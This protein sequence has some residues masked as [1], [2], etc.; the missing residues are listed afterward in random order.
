MAPRLDKIYSGCGF[1]PHVDDNP[2]GLFLLALEDF[3]NPRPL[4]CTQS[5]CARPQEV[6]LPP[7]GKNMNWWVQGELNPAFGFSHQRST[8]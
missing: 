6:H 1:G 5:R 2:F 8:I 4:Y 7:S 3:R